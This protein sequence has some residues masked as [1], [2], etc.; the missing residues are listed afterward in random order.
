MLASLCKIGKSFGDWGLGT[1]DWGLGTGDWGLGIGDWGLGIGDWGLGIGDW[2]LGNSGPPLGIR[3]N[4]G[5]GKFRG[6][7]NFQ[8]LNYP[9]LAAKTII[10]LFFLCFLCF[11]CSHSLPKR[12][13]IFLCGIPKRVFWLRWCDGEDRWLR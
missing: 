13:V 1:G 6:L 4:W 3:G 8:K 7:G 5:L 12:L 9:F 2:G 10:V 11:L